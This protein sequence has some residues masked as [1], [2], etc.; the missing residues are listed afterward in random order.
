MTERANRV[1]HEADRMVQRLDSIVGLDDTQRDQVFGIMARGSRDYDPAMMIEGARGEI[2]TIPTGDRM[3]SM[4]AVLRPDQR[5]AFE[6]ERQHRRE[7]AMKDMEAIGLTL[8][9]NWEMLDWLDFH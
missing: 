1:Q 8:P 3:A 7:E 5:A 9:P 6:A 4:L 2:G